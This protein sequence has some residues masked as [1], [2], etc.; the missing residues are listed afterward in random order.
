MD[1]ALLARELVREA[2]ALA[3]RIRAE[4]LDV[5]RKTSG[6]DIVTQADTAAERLI[7]ERLAA[8]R[9]DDAVVGEE[10]AAKD[11]TSG[12]TWVID[13]VDGTYNF[14]RGSDWWCSALALRD[15]DDVLL[16]AVYHPASQRTWVGGPDLP[17]TCDGEPVAPLPDTPRE[18]RCAATYLHPPFFEGE[19]GRVFS[20]ALREVGTLRM[21]GSGT[22]DAM[23]IAMGQG[24]VLFQHSVAD[25][26]RLPGAAIIRGAGGDSVVVP[27]AGVEW[28]VSGA[29]RAVADVSR[30]FA[31]SAQS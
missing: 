8:E 3:A 14:S 28:T 31:E 15:E 2:G 18:E 12:R 24:D 16:G 11:G 25:W 5:T 20:L 23:A 9:P 26:D 21:L 27:A 17:S 13:P 1:D 22:M 19:V 6:S 7:V 4:G 30:A 29:L 10:G